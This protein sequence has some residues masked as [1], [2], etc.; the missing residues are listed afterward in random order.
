M[1]PAMW[2][3]MTM[4]LAGLIAARVTAAAWFM[5]DGV[6]RLSTA[7]FQVG[8]RCQLPSGPAATPRASAAE[9]SSPVS[10][11]PGAV[12]TRPAGQPCLRASGQPYV[13]ASGQP[14]YQR[15]CTKTR[16]KFLE[17][18]STR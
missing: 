8:F 14:R 15:K 16:P 6:P 10:R 12:P 7:A 18:F 3:S 13:R 5:L 4:G 9:Q 2:M 11:E 17:S 1:R